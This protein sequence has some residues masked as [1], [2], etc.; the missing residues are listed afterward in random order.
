VLQRYQ[1]WY[2]GGG[3]AGSLIRRLTHTDIASTWTNS[4]AVWSR[5]AA[6]VLE[7]IRNVEQTVP[8]VLLGLDLDNGSEWLDR[9][10]IRCLRDPSAPVWA[11]RSRRYRSNYNTHVDQERRTWRRQLLRNGRLEDPGLHEPI[12]RVY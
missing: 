12:T 3:L 11:A 1:E 8:F 9:Q 10:L 5:S 7:Q 2:V 4:R 6:G